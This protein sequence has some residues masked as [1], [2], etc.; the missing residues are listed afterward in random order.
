MSFKDRFFYGLLRPP[1]T[2]FLRLKFGYT[3]DKAKKLPENYIVLSNHATDFDPLFVASSFPRQMYFVGSEHIS[4]WRVFPLIKFLVDPIIRRK[5]TV[6]A[7]TVTDI[8]RRTR[9]GGSVCVFAEGIRTWDGVTCPIL[10]S[11]GRLIKSAGCGLVTYKITGGYFA[12]PNWSEGSGTRRG[13]VHGSPVNIYTKEQLAGMTVDEINEIINRDLHE[14][15]YERQ[16]AQPRRYKGKNLAEKL[17]NLLFVCPECG[18]RDSFVSKKSHVSCTACGFGFDYD[19]YGMLSGAPYKTVYDFARWQGEQVAAD[20]AN[21]VAYTS[22]HATLIQI[23]KDGET[24]VA[25]GALS[26]DGEALTCGGTVIAVSDI[27][28]LDIHGR[29]AI[30]FAAN[31]CYYE[32]TPCRD[33]NAL[34]YLLLFRE[35]NKL[36]KSEKVR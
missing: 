6:A 13:P 33:S 28:N 20:A 24:P 19:E 35:Y 21:G 8:L 25:D 1:I 18:A 29:H 32:L 2:L 11:T 12:S 3:Y 7:S 17:E 14:N 22:P 36:N 34:K 4:R 5:G 9:K 26:L 27:S 23:S 16:L 31:S 30:V 15:A 10:P